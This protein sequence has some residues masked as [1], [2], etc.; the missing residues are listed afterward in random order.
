LITEKEA[1]K[2][3]AENI[4]LRLQEK[5]ISKAEFARIIGSTRQIVNKTLESLE[6]GS[7]TLKTICKLAN[8]LDIEPKQLLEVLEIEIK[9]KPKGE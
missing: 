6:N 8:G 9:L 2:I 3:M 5:N 7:G 1:G 4:K